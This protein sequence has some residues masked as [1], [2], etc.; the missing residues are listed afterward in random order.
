[1]RVNRDTTAEDRLP[2]KT[3]AYFARIRESAARRHMPT[4]TRADRKTCC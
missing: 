1:M 4:C 2:D 3:P